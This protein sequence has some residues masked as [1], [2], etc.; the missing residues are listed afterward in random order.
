MADSTER[1]VFD[2]L[3]RDRNASRTFRQVGDA[4]DRAG[5]SVT[6]FGKDAK[7]LDKQIDTTEKHLKDL[8]TEFD[9]TGDKTLF[10]DVRKDRS[11]LTLLQAMKKEVE[12][13]PRRNWFAGIF[14]NLGD[15][16]QVLPSKLKGAAIVG[17]AGAGVALAP[18]LGAAVA[19]AILG[20]VGTGGIIGGVT[21]AAQDDRVAAAGKQL[22]QHLLGELKADGQSFVGPVLVAIE[23]LD[24]ATTDLLSDVG[25]E[26][27]DMS[28]LVV[29]LSRG[30]GGLVR[31]LGPG[32]SDALR[33]S[34]PVIR[35]IAE[36]LPELGKSVSYALSAISEESDGAA[37]G[38]AEVFHI[39]EYGTEFV[40]DLVANLSAAY[41]WLV[42]TDDQFAAWGESWFGWLPIA[43]DAMSSFHD[44]TSAMVEELDKAKST[45][46]TYVGSVDALGM[47]MEEQAQKTKDARQALVEYGKSVA[48]QFDPT[49]NLY[50]RLG[51][52]KK[53]HEDYDE[54]V[55]EN[56]KNSRE[57]KDA[58]VALGEA[59]LAVQ[60]A[61]LG[62]Q[63]TF[64]GK[65]S[66][67][68]VKIFHDAG[69]ADDQIRAMEKSLRA[70][71]AAGES[72]AKPYKAQLI[73]DTSR[74]YGSLAAARNAAEGNEYVSGR[75]SGGPV[76]SGKTYMV[77]E[78]GP[79]LVTFGADGFVHNAQ[80]TQAMLAG[81][82]GG[83]SGAYGGSGTTIVNL[84]FP[85][86]SGDPIYDGVVRELREGV[87]VEG[88]GSVQV[89]FNGTTA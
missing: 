10:R 85:G 3:A 7:Q 21:L 86:P 44:E 6:G 84:N 41:E 34:E 32:L 20:G 26:F 42:R 88:G 75:A 64:D 83:S 11:V 76:M 25:D 89:F 19:G 37:M 51:D 57:A 56:G 58:L 79:E 65:F 45:T 29:P 14:D 40:G 62:A 80:Q 49:A 43:G 15:T 8:I 5:D 68:L 67:A 47:S 31:N 53:A 17:A 23:Q 50:H 16:L 78:E 54:A 74:F 30:I 33:K 27:R 13:P 72:F 46:D 4:A 81:T 9:R 48:D 73:L 66:P 52:L 39:I 59:A 60:A 2:I 77:G 36:E 63:G 70:A 24:D 35:V 87:R 38:L 1:L 55:K 12:E 28:K 61:A 71:K 69:I 18:F 22:G 82:S